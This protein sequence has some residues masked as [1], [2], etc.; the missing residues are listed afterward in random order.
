MRDE[1]IV[2]EREEVKGEREK[3]REFVWEKKRAGERHLA[4]MLSMSSRENNPVKA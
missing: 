2:R 3:R 1:E 4:S